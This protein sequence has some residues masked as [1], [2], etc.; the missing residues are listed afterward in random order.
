MNNERQPQDVPD[1]SNQSIK[2]IAAGLD[3]CRGESSA[4]VGLLTSSCS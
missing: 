1:E 2:H 4:V 3:G